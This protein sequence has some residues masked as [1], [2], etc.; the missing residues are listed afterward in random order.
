M[1]YDHPLTHSITP[2]ISSPPTTGYLVFEMSCGYELTTLFPTDEDYQ[3]VRARDRK[4]EEVL[5]YIFAEG[6]TH[7]IT[8]V[9]ECANVI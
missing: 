8:E 5:R 2:S 6:F 3:A 4:L 1:S 7:G 9:S